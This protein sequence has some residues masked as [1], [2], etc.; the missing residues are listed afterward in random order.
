MMP[1]DTHAQAALEPLATKDL[2]RAEGERLREH[3]T[4]CMQRVR[5]DIYSLID[6]IELM[7]YIDT[8]GR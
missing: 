7:T 2:I 1:Q 5:R 8:A 4:I 3:I 6:A